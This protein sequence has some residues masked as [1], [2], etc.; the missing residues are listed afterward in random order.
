MVEV[1]RMYILLMI[2]YK[3]E[4]YSLGTVPGTWKQVS[5]LRFIFSWKSKTLE[6]IFKNSVPPREL[7]SSLYW[8]KKQCG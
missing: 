1:N 5:T 4:K 6:Y 3:L 2:T 7:A 8:Q